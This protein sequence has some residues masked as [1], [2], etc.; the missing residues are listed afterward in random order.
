LFLIGLGFY[1]RKDAP[2]APTPAPVVKR[3]APPSVTPPAP[4][5]APPAP[6]PD[7]PPAGSRFVE[8]LESAKRQRAGSIMKLLVDGVLRVNDAEAKRVA[9]WLMPQRFNG[10]FPYLY[11]VGFYTAKQPGKAYEGMQYI[12]RGALIYR[13]DAGRCGDPTSNQAVPIIE[14][15]IGIPTIRTRLKEKPASRQ[16]IVVDALAFEMTTGERPLP[17]WIC[18]H[19]I[20]PGNPPDEKTFQAH[21]DSVRKQ[22]VA[23]Y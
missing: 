23:G 20:R 18:A 7:V 8:E 2:R 11:F 9:E 16:L 12:A 21:R 13:I 14:S 4:Q 22:F 1:L 3:E 6:A 5:V 15:A 10:D 19:G 17:R